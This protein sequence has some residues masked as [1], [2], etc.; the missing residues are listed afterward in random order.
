MNQILHIMDQILPV[1]DNITYYEK[2][3]LVI[4]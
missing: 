4:D 2:M 1:I 3:L